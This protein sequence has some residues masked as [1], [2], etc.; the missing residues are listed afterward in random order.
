MTLG[1]FFFS[2]RALGK[3]SEGHGF[4]FFSIWGKL[5]VFFSRVRNLLDWVI[6]QSASIDYRYLGLKTY[7]NN[8]GKP[9]KNFELLK[10]Y[11]ISL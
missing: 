3:L 9:E 1:K 4:N 10:N 6:L 2:V 11:L 7:K 5:A 8:Y